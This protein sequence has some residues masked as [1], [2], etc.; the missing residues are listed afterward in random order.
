MNKTTI[1]E[2]LK[3]F[4]KRLVPLITTLIGAVIGGLFDT[5]I[6]IALGSATG[7]LMSGIQNG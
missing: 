2:A 1:F 7:I 3:T 6:P 5:D 4:G